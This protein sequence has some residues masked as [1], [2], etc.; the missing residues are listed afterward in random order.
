MSLTTC[1]W[2]L[3]LSGKTSDQLRDRTVLL[4]YVLTRSSCLMEHSPLFS[5]QGCRYFGQARGIVHLN[6]NMH[7]SVGLSF[8][9]RSCLESVFL[10]ASAAG[11]PAGSGTRA[12]R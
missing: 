1:R 8:S 4:P 2:R 5:G 7:G 12:R 6:G 9:D 11:Y 10:G 3:P